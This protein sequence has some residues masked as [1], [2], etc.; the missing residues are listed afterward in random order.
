MNALG[1]A[2][3]LWVPLAIALQEPGAC[4]LL[5]GEASHAAGSSQRDKQKPERKT[6]SS[7]TL[8]W[9]GLTLCQMAQENTWRAHVYCHRTSKDNLELKVNKS[10]H[11]FDYSTSICNILY[12]FETHI[13]MKQFCIFTSF[14]IQLPFLWLKNFSPF[15]LNEEMYNCNCAI[16]HINNLQIQAK[17]LWKFYYLQA[18]LES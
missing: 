17:S 15:P 5:T 11:T 16:T 2:A 12:T 14:M 7:C 9:Q 10:I 4:A 18:T 13:A 1:E 8:Y 3:V 6:L